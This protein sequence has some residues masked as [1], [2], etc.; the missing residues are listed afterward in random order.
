MKESRGSIVGSIVLSTKACRSLLLHSL[1]CPSLNASLSCHM[2][3]ASPF[4]P[5]LPSYTHDTCRPM[6][7]YSNLLFRKCQ[8]T[9]S[10]ATP[11]VHFSPYDF[12]PF[13]RNIFWP[14]EYGKSVALCHHSEQKVVGWSPG[15]TG[16]MFVT[17]NTL[18][19]N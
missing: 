2:L 12:L 13:S 10:F 6:T 1:I 3:P 8:R 5:R 16:R 19:D 15:G 14:E 17:K 9:L 4:I 11:L 7:D 18:R